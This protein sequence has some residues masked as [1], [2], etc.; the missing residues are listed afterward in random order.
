MPIELSAEARK[1]ATASL[2]RYCT[3]E[4]D[5][6]VSGIQAAGLLDFFLKE[7]GPSVYNGAMRDAAAFML[8]RVEDLEASCFEGEFTYWVKGSGAR[9]K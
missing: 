8:G 7:I 3:A 2:E 4:L 5:A 9:R 1:Q 6:E